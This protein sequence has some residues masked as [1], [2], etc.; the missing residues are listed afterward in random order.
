MKDQLEELD[1]IV[2]NITEAIGPENDQIKE[3]ISRDEKLQQLVRQKDW[4]HL[5]LSQQEQVEQVIIR[6]DKLFIVESGELGLI[7]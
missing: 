4:S 3:G 7:Q 5:T 1:S 2:G 6:Y